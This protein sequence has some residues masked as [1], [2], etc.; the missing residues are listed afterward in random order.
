MA[1]RQLYDHD[2]I[3]SGCTLPYDKG[4]KYDDELWTFVTNY[5][6]AFICLF[7][8]L[9]VFRVGSHSV[10]VILFFGMT[11]AL[12]AYAGVLHQTD[13]APD[14]KTW[15][16]I[17]TWILVIV[18]SAFLTRAGM[19]VW[20]DSIWATLLWTVAYSAAL[21]MALVL[22][23]NIVVGVTTIVSY[24]AAVLLFVPDYFKI[25]GLLVCIG[26]FIVQFILAED[27]G[28]DGYEDCFES[29]PLPDPI[30]FNHN[31][32][33]HSIWAVGLTIFA[34]TEYTNPLGETYTERKSNTR[35]HTPSERKASA[36]TMDM[37]DMH[38]QQ[39]NAEKDGVVKDLEDAKELNA[40]VID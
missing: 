33:F 24:G 23:S 3:A 6:V 30:T 8:A 17:I 15:E 10:N 4:T 26:G 1:D 27:C 14:L 39:A 28:D 25:I 36:D 20:T 21:T 34:I 16:K 29:C 11:G 22:D 12:N 35:K 40:E 31:A 13:K 18:S 19:R 9:V 5:I 7:C 2:F 38:H 32:L 37:S